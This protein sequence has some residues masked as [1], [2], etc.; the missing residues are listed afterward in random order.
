M[1]DTKNQNTP[2]ASH[3]PE[4]WDYDT[5]FIVAPDPAGEHPDIYIAEIAHSDDEGRIAPYEQH[6]ANGRRICAAV[7][8]CEGISTEALE[9][10]VIAEMRH[11]LGELVTTAGDLDA[12]I[13]GVTDQF[14]A[15]R[16]RLNATIQAAQAILDGGMEIDLDEL[17]SSHCKIALVWCI[18]DVQDVRPDLTNEQA[19]EV[20][21]QVKHNHDADIGVNWYTLE[22]NAEDLFGDAPETVAEQEQS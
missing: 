4:P 13:D 17:L 12:A 2:A 15:E 20:L 1:I 9:R 7:N 18:E 10:G 22:W 21:R 6:E 3:T 5:G 8:A 16:N 19:W 14:N 11:I